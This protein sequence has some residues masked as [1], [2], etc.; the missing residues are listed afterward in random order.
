MV[1]ASN[2]MNSLQK[3][4][5]TYGSLIL[6][7]LIIFFLLFLRDAYSVGINKYIFLGITCVCV[8]YM[9]TSDLIYLYCFLFPLYVGL[10]GNYMTLVLVVRLLLETR[11]FK[12]TSLVLTLFIAAFM[13]FQNYTTGNIGITHMMYIPGLFVVL[14]LFTHRQKLDIMPMVLMYS[15]GVAALGFI[16]LV[17]TLRVHSLVDLMSNA[18]R[19]GTSNSAYTEENIMRVS[20]DPNFYG[21]FAISAISL[22]FPLFLH[23]NTSKIRKAWF[24][25]FAFIQLVVALT[26]LSRAFILVLLLWIAISLFTQRSVRNTVFAV[27]TVGVFLFFLVIYMSDV[28][29]VVLSRFYEEDILTANGRISGIL[30]FWSIWSSSLYYI[31]LGVGLFRCNVH[32]VPLQMLFGGGLIYSILMFALFMSYKPVKPAQRSLVGRLPFLAT[33]IMMCSVPAAPLLNYMFPL[34]IVGLCMDKTKML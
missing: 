3:T 7:A 12:A 18:F 24:I 27:I 15:A 17:S 14:M 1:M 26:G 5:K 25:I 9:K 28:I 32:C 30:R 20:V 4:K 21:A 22:A 13:V 10:P 2:T 23:P 8:F 19:L 31:F 34:V 16:M 29:D 33:S 6:W 11:R